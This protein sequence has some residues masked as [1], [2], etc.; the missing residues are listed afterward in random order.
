MSTTTT[1]PPKLPPAWFKHAFWRG[2]RVLHRVSG[3][4]F[5][6]P[7]TSKRGWGAM[8]LTT[9]GRKSGRPRAVIVGYLEDGPNPI[10]LAMNGWDP[11]HPAWWL[12]LQADPDAVIRL[13]RQQP[14]AVRARTASGAERERLWQR[15]L[16][17]EPEIDAFAREH[18]IET[19]IV[20]FE[21]LPPQPASATE[22]GFG[23]R[24]RRSGNV[25]PPGE[26]PGSFATPAWPSLLG[27]R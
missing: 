7:P 2:H 6:W 23:H 11:G 26:A 10:V 15:W 17:I 9:I 3:G 14:L 19:P 20:V 8:H 18:D 16:A 12:N 22:L 27:R 4:R 21:L 1:R 5:L 24:A 13:P 25:T